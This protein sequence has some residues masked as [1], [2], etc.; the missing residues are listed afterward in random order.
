MQS[1]ACLLKESIERWAEALPRTTALQDIARRG[2][3]HP[4]AFAQYLESL[5]LLFVESQRSLA[6]AAERAEQL[7]DSPLAAY[8]RRK[9]EE[10]HG[11]EAWASADLAQ[12]TAA[13]SDGVAPA[14][15]IVRL[16]ELQRE[17]ITQHPICFVAY[18]LWA[19]Y[20]TVLLGDEW[21][22]A[23]AANG[24]GREQV[25]S[26]AKHVAADREH[27]ATGFEVLE[28]LWCGQ[29]DQATLLRGVD[30][31]CEAFRAFCDEIC[32]ASQR[33]ARGALVC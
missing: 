13:E 22:D 3:L 12:L 28:R 4:R 2:E 14:C 5:R 21:L 19:E 20:F 17:L 11:H 30:R 9:V 1:V 18:A 33:A 29:P 8:F 23:L 26:V 24:Y 27:A 31:A 6:L 16:V 32:V 15:S 7:G 25:S 10:E